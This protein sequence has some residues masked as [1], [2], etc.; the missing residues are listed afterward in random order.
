MTIWTNFSLGVYLIIALFIPED[1]QQ[2]VPQDPPQDG[3]Q[4]L[5]Q[6]EPQQDQFP[7]KLSEQGTTLPSKIQ[8]MGC[9][10]PGKKSLIVA[11][12]LVQDLSLVELKPNGV[13]YH[14]LQIWGTMMGV[15]VSNT[16]VAEHW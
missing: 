15:V 8:P 9:T 3:Q 4:G 7:D 6:D 11:H 13:N 2:G 5:P 16:I 14:T 1:Q 12:I 10:N